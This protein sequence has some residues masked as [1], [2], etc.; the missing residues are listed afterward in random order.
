[1]SPPPSASAPLAGAVAA[2]PSGE[3]DLGSRANTLPRELSDF[4]LELSVALHKHA[5]YPPGHPLLAHAV[6]AVHEQLGDLLRERGALSIGV[7]RR[8]LIIEGVATDAG[9]PL[10]AELAAKLH[11]HHVG[12]LKFARGIDRAELS[13]ALSVV[14]LEPQRDAQPIGMQPELLLSR[15]ANVKL[16]P[17]TY[18]RLQLLDADHEDASTGGLR[19]GGHSAQL[20]VGLARAAIAADRGGA[21]GEDVA[22]EPEAVAHAI[23]EH[24]RE[25]A[26]DQVIV[27][28]LLQIAREVKTEGAETAGL[29]KRISALVGSLQPETLQRLLEMGGDAPQRRRFVLDASQGM[30]VNAVVD[31]VRAAATAEGQTISHSLVR[32]LTKLASHATDDPTSR[33]PA[34]DRALREHVERLV[35]SWS[36]DDPNPTTYSAALEHMAQN[37]A[38]PVIDG[39]RAEL[40]C[41]PWRIVAMGLEMDDIGDRVLRAVNTMLDA[42]TLAPLLDL[43]DAA[44]FPTGTLAPMIWE[45][46]CVRDP[47]RELLTESRLDHALVRRLVVRTGPSAVR[48]L[49]ETLDRRPEASL[50]ERLLSYIALLGPAAVPAIADHLA[51][52]TPSL[53]R[54]LMACLAKMAPPDAPPEAG[55][56]T[57]HPDPTLRREA[58]RLLAAYPDT[59]EEALLSG[60]RDPDERV[61]YSA[62]LAAQAGCPEPVAAVIRERMNRDEWDELSVRAAAVRA[63]ATI[64]DDITLE[65]VLSRVL[66]VGGL[67]RRKRVA[68]ATPEVLASLSVLATHW[69]DDPRA[70]PAL[71]LALKSSRASIRAAAQ[72]DRSQ[73]VS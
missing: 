4:L 65:W 2:S 10:L 46:I 40:A 12:A 66:Q 61:A 64:R 34:A 7:A 13:D 41:E 37:E 71:A 30:T 29:Q 24:D 17:L 69:A 31:L 3:A 19:G 62:L 36:L 47:L 32:M 5:I 48:S 16:F 23:D 15:W 54:E 55:P 49:L 56:F 63:A 45:R 35:T 25:K 6:D 50:Q 38:A 53:A 14:G 42:G 20:W 22:M 27:G 1:M 60:V 43:L 59:R 8:Q 28:Y 70:A 68:P 18:D 11:R 58:V 9:H 33:G 67:L 73:M 21:S 72:L 39:V 26:Y 44:P 52:A 57:Y 51:N